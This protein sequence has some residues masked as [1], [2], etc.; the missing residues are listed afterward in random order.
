Q[1]GAPLAG[2][3]IIAVLDGQA[4]G[5]VEFYLHPDNLALQVV[6]VQ[7]HLGFRKRGLAFLLRD[8]L[9]EA[10]P[11]AW[12]NHGLRTDE[13]ARWW[14]R[15][16]DPAPERNV[17]N[18]PTAEWTAYFLAPGVDRGP[19]ANRVWNQLFALDGHQG[20]EHRY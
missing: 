7:V 8:R 13:G 3:Q 2:R 19:A 1:S 11:D 9:Y 12:I 17:H 4:V 6:G 18:R 16:R 15:Y 5:H 20:A 14:H 10:H